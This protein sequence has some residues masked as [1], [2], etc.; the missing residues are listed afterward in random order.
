M[1]A[2]GRV[3]C[4]CVLAGLLTGTAVPAHASPRDLVDDGAPGLLV[5]D[6]EPLSLQ[7]LLE[8][9]DSASWL[10]TPT[11]DAVGGAEVTLEVTRS[12]VLALHP[13][14]ITFQLDACSEAWQSALGSD[15]VCTGTETLLAPRTPFALMTA[16]PPFVLGTVPD[17]GSMH[18]RVL[19]ALPDLV[20]SELQGAEAEFA[21]GFSA[22]GDDEVV[23]SEPHA[24]TPGR[25][26]LS[27]TGIALGAPLALALLL[28]AAGAVM[29]FA[30]RQGARH[31][32]E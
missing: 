24:G 9:G 4:G 18:L 10:L 8:P 3:V 17:G 26:G 20:P 22:A 14:G 5:I 31:E 15:P 6:A 27:L 11:V 28:G 32:V 19:I 21:L 12:G 29:T 1:N 23:T 16:G 25:S 13:Q 30:S 2:A 7:A